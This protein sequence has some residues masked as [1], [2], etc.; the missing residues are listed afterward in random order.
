[1]NLVDSVDSPLW[2]ICT[3]DGKFKLRD[4]SINIQSCSLDASPLDWT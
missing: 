4:A 3:I 1:M 2:V